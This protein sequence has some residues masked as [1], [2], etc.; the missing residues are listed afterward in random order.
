MVFI[1]SLIIWWFIEQNDVYRVDLKFQNVG[2]HSWVNILFYNKF[3]AFVNTM[4]TLRANSLKRIH[5]FHVVN[6][7]YFIN[8]VS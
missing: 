7:C 6:P 3:I 5:S 8:I 1:L 4:Y 2:W